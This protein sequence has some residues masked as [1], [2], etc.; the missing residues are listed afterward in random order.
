MAE[1]IN[2]AIDSRDVKTFEEKTGLKFVDGMKLLMDNLKYGGKLGLDPFWSEEN[3]KHLEKSINEFK[4]GKVVSFSA[5]EWE[6]II[7]AQAIQ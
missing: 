6:K 2:F 4:E 7:N 1:M 5:E 3:Q